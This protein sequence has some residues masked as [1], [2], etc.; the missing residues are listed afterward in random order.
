M[1]VIGNGNDTDIKAVIWISQLTAPRKVCRF[2]QRDL[3]QSRLIKCSSSNSNKIIS[4]LFS[5]FLGPGVPVSAAVEAGLDSGLM[6]GPIDRVL[7]MRVLV[8]QPASRR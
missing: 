6:R 1:I 2:Y 3:F 4:G 7:A 5:A 8:G